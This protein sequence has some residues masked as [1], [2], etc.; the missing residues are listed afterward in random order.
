MDGHNSEFSAIHV[1]IIFLCDKTTT[2][3]YAD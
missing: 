2:D 1:N 3:K